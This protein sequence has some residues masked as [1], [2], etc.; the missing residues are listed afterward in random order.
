MAGKVVI[1][2]GARGSGKS[3]ILAAVRGKY[4]VVTIGDV[5]F[6][7]AQREGIAKDRDSMRRLGNAAYDRLKLKAYTEIAAMGGNIIL[8][9]HATVEHDGRFIPG[10]PLL[11]IKRL[12]NIAGLFYIDVDQDS[13]LARYRR[14]KTRVREEEPAQVLLD[15][16]GVSIATLSYYSA[17]LNIPIYIINN[18]DGKLQASRKKFLKHLKDAFEN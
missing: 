12:K 15:N 18:E 1:V 17:Y 14:D 11:F 4:K 9:T 2:V 13:L 3:S 8:N 6:R 10:L 7:I 16:R 5:L